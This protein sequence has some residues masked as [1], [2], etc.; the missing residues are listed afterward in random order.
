[1]Q[2]LI[3]LFGS[4]ACLL[5]CFL[6][7]AQPA[8]TAAEYY[9][10]NDPGRGNGTAVALAG[11]PNLSFTYNFSSLNNG[12]HLIGVRSKDA[13]GAWS[14]DAKWLFVKPFPVVGG[15]TAP[16]IASAEYYIDNDPG[17]GNGTPISMT[18]LPDLSF[19]YN[20]SSLNSGVHLIGVRTKDANGVWGLDAKW[21]FVKPFPV[22]SGGTAP[23]VTAAEYYIDNDPG[24][25]NGTAIALAGLP[26]LN[27]NYDFSSLNSGVHLIG[28]R[29][30][31]ANGAWSLDAKWLFLK[32][33]PSVGGNTAPAIVAA[34]YFIDTDPGKGNG[35]P[36]A[37]TALSNISN[38][39]FVGNLAGLSNA[40]H[41]LGVRTKD[42]N[43]A[44]SLDALYDFTLTGGV[45]APAIS[46]TTVINQPVFCA[47]D[48]LAFAFAANGTY[49][50]GNIFT[51]ELSD[52]SGNFGS[53]QAFGTLAS[54][55]GGALVKFK[56]PGN[57]PTGTGYK[58]RVNSSNP[59]ATGL[60]SAATLAINN[61]PQL[62]PDATVNLNCIGETADLNPL[63][64]VSGLTFSWNTVNT[65]TAPA[66]TYRLIA[67]N[68]NG[69]SDTAFAVV[70]VEVATWTGSVSSDWHVAGNWNI[71]KVPGNT[72]H[73]IIPGGTANAC[74]LSAADGQAASLQVRTGANVQINNNRKVDVVQK[75]ATLP[76]N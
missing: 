18:G 40:A 24:K 26:N 21:L 22:V 64:N 74:V 60:A 2:K 6:A 76:S 37:L 58:I 51:A 50:A 35:K 9:I 41:K 30:K 12:V 71:G 17:W 69:C 49:N 67:T 19:T 32:A 7:Q 16:A 63:F 11:L 68:A 56:L 31:D 57:V 43:G 55:G 28:V 42:A 25:G 46:I 75:C 36:I 65:T 48:S 38:L 34:E 29:T 3:K 47:A 1:M 53:P 15:G 8:I 23:A 10:D 59:A 45:P 13:N 73:V 5:C 39:Q 66:G 14:L 72:T 33:F 27:F 54:T 44:W 20:L 4:F 52:A 70:Q 62:G 61:R